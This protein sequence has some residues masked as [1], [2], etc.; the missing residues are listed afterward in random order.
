[1]ETDRTDHDDGEQFDQSDFDPCS[2]YH[3]LYPLVFSE[4]FETIMSSDFISFR[5]ERIII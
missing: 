2:E 4:I 5:S 1:M 3:A